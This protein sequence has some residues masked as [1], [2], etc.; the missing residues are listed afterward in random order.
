MEP[1]VVVYKESDPATE[2]EIGKLLEEDLLKCCGIRVFYYREEGGNCDHSEDHQGEWAEKMRDSSNLEAGTV[3][4]VGQY[5]VSSVTGPAEKFHTVVIQW[6][7]GVK[8]AY[9]KE[10]L[11]KSYIRVFDLGPAGMYVF[12]STS[13]SAD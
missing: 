10:Q 11:E 12:K 13:H 9:T 4:S 7:C 2:A 5:S 8:R 6:D 3:I 1:P